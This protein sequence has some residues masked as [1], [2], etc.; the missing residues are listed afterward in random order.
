M[1]YKNNKT[2]NRRRYKSRYRNA[3]NYKTKRSASQT[4][5]AII[6]AS[7]TFIVIAA[8]VVVFAFGDRIY[9]FISS[10]LEPNIETQQDVTQSTVESTVAPTEKPTEKPTQAPTQAPLVDDFASLLNGA[11]LTEKDV[12][13]SQMIF[14]Y[15]EGTSCT[16][17]C[18]QKNSDGK[19]EEEKEPINGYVSSNGIK[20]E[21][22][23]Y[24]NYTPKG[25]FNIEFAFGTNS[26]PGTK[27]D[28]NL[29][30]YSTYW[31]TDPNSVNYNR[32]VDGSAATHDWSD[33]QW[34][35][36]YTVS[37]PYAV[38]F[39]YNRDPVSKSEGC[40]KFLHVSYGETNGGIGISEN[41]LISVLQ[42]LDKS[43]SPMITIF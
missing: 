26:D 28:Y 40:A 1:D 23:P 13:G 43:Q 17:Y 16:L 31:I 32:L 42:W 25:T 14:A 39:D 34:L 5:V 27:L 38:V 29:V 20:T 30:D 36:E 18:Y 3:H 35:Y 6:V 19:W 2:Q 4:R 12:K 10:N 7:V 24:D 41:E 9:S 21:M 15:N 8:V 33:A 22:G 11:G 37:Y